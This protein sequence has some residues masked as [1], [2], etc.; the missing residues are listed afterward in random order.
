METTDLSP[1]L[2]NLEH[3]LDTLQS[4]LQ[5]LRAQPLA[6]IANKLPLLDQAK[7]YVLV[8]YAVE[9]LI[10]SYLRLHGVDAKEHRVYRELI[11]TKQYFEK[12]KGVENPEATPGRGSLVVDKE[13]AGRFIKHALQASNN[14]QTKPKPE[15]LSAANVTD[16]NKPN[17]HIHF[18][19]PNP[20]SPSRKRKSPHSNV[21]ST[22]TTEPHTPTT[23]LAGPLETSNA[24]SAA[25]SATPTEEDDGSRP[26][27]QKR[28][29]NHEKKKAK[30]D[31]RMREAAAAA[32]AT[33]E[34]GS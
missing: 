4:A 3:S 5:P 15:H 24:S 16:P 18:P 30:R 9:S 19:D 21:H 13:A 6:S 34:G 20:S 14:L 8:T 29:E 28:R 12:I 33:A 31:A 23:P 32:A 26:K 22:S 10:F 25:P 2:L 1:L 17:T 27:K 11:R 7:L